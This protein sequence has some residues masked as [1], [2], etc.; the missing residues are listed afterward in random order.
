MVCICPQVV[1]EEALKEWP[2]PP[3]LQRGGSHNKSGSHESLA[4]AIAEN[5]SDGKIPQEATDDHKPVPMCALKF[6]ELTF[7]IYCRFLA[8]QQSFNIQYCCRRLH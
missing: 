4:R 6:Q 3:G 7:L 8:R 2:I 5:P 1:K